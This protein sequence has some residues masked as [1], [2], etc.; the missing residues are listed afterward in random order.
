MTQFVT[1]YLAHTLARV[2][3]LLDMYRTAEAIEAL[4]A[5]KT[6]PNAFAEMKGTARHFFHLIVPSYEG[7]TWGC[8]K[9]V[10]RWTCGIVAMHRR[11][12]KGGGADD[13]A[14]YGVLDGILRAFRQQLV[15]D[16][17][18]CYVWRQHNL[19]RSRHDAMVT[20]QYRVTDAAMTADYCIG[21]IMTFHLYLDDCLCDSCKE[22]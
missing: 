10:N 21:R 12:D 19:H 8:A 4:V 7:I 17:R 1:D 6:A 11:N 2:S 3:P 9:E 15:A 20:L 5:L 16:S 13:A 14:L 22:D 18:A